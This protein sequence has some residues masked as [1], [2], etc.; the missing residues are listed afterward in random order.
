MNPF[1]L[2]FGIMTKLFSYLWCFI[3]RIIIFRRKW[4]VLLIYCHFNTLF[5]NDWIQIV[6]MFLSYHQH[7]L[8]FLLKTTMHVISIL[9][10]LIISNC[11]HTSAMNCWRKFQSLLILFFAIMI[12]WTFFPC[13]ILVYL[14]FLLQSLIIWCHKII[15]VG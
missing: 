14:R 4:S 7:F 9:F 13:H 12:N 8:L 10:V 2:L 5:Q 11:H 6:W 3:A 1:W 15:D